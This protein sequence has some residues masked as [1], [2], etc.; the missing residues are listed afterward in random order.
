MQ[1]QHGIVERV[2]FL[3]SV[4]RTVRVLK[5]CKVPLEP[6][7]WCGGCTGVRS[8][9]KGVFS[10]LLWFSLTSA[11][12]RFEKLALFSNVSLTAFGVTY[13]S[14]AVFKE[15]LLVNY[16]HLYRRYYATTVSHNSR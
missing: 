6:P 9:L 16:V 3:L 11:E 10:L 15:V 2:F 14:I 5:S 8:R 13:A 4:V 12:G 1:F 7:G